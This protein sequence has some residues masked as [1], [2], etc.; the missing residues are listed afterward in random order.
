[1][2]R[3]TR[4]RRRGGMAKRREID[5]IRQTDQ[6]KERRGLALVKSEQS[7]EKMKKRQAK[8]KKC[9]DKRQQL[10]EE[11]AVRSAATQHLAP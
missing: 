8:R 4:K 9:K 5:A 2:I 7:P 3:T 6:R 10:A 1:M 11:R